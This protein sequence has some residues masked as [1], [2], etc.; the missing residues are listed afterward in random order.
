MTPRWYVSFVTHGL[1]IKKLLHNLKLKNLKELTILELTLAGL[2]VLESN[3]E[4]YVSK[5]WTVF[6]SQNLV[7]STVDTQKNRLTHISIF[8][9]VV[10]FHMVLSSKHN[11]QHTAFLLFASAFQ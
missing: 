11:S 3:S 6:K 2:M 10:S 9:S 1:N 4:E 8:I 7:L 5:V